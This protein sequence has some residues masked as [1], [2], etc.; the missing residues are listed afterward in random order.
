MEDD[1]ISSLTMDGDA[2]WAAHGMHASKYLRG[3]KVRCS[4][5][6]LGYG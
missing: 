6:F 1:T 5:R 2:V 4:S 3:K